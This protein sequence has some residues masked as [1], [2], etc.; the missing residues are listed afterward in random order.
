MSQ[1]TRGEPLN[2]RK[3]AT[4]LTALGLIPAIELNKLNLE[5]LIGR[6]FSSQ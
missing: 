1:K 4:L 5:A 2:Q 6:D 3:A